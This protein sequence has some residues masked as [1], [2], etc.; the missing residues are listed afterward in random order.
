MK[1]F[2]IAIKHLKDFDFSEYDTYLYDGD[3]EL[4]KKLQIEF[5]SCLDSFKNDKDN[6]YSNDYWR[7]ICFGAAFYHLGDLAHN[8]P[9]WFYVTCEIIESEKELLKNRFEEYRKTVYPKLIVE[10]FDNWT[11]T[12]NPKPFFLSDESEIKLD[13]FASAYHY[14]GY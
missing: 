13:L 14:L 8:R 5:D 10:K 11:K 6:T 3:G 2:D 7:C 4:P 9:S 1:T 12:L